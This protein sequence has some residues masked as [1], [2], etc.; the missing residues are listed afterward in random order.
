MQCIVG[1]AYLWR[2]REMLPWNLD[3]ASRQHN[4]AMCLLEERSHQEHSHDALK[5]C[6]AH[7]LTSIDS[8]IVCPGGKKI[9]IAWNL[10]QMKKKVIE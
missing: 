7:Q 10:V 8:K 5:Y 2:R 3:K 6:L 1:F 9:T 4:I